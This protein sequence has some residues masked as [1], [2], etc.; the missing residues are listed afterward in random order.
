[1]SRGTKRT[2]TQS[3]K[4]KFETNWEEANLDEIDTEIT[5]YTN[6]LK[7][8]QDKVKNQKKDGITQKQKEEKIKP[9]LEHIAYCRQQLILFYKLK[10]LKTPFYDKLPK[11][12]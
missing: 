3:K 9:F 12:N 11:E 8:V 4:S 1:M 7:N 10:D 5:K 6:D 2:A